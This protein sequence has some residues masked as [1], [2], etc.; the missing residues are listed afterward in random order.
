MREVRM[1]LTEGDLAILDKFHFDIQPVGVKFLVERPDGI[2]R[3]TENMAFCEM[4]K[5]AQEGNAFHADVENHTCPAGAY[6]LGQEDAKGPF[7]SGQ[8]GAGLR[9]FEDT[10]AASRLYLYP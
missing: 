3:L 2:G 7:I 6:V 4:L 9:I 10:R 1:T 5:R 8:F